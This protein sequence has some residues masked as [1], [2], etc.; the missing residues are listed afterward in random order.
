VVGRARDL[1]RRLRAAGQGPGPVVVF[2]HGVFMRVVA[3][4]LLAG[5]EGAPDAAA[6][7]AFKRFRDAT[8]IPNT[9]LLELAIDDI[10][11][12]RLLCGA[13]AHLPPS[14]VT[15]GP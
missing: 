1:A 10:G 6:M 5:G 15:G 12:A 9:A 2:T 14:L 3:W 8:L 13:D 11:T 4:C 7:R